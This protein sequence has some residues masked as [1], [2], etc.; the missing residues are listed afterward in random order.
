MKG[1][2]ILLE[3]LWE[4]SEEKI[5]GIIVSIIFTIIFK[6]ISP[7]INLKEE[8]K[9]KCKKSRCDCDKFM[10][11]QLKIIGTVSVIGVISAFIG[12]MVCTYF[13]FE[14]VKAITMIRWSISIICACTLIFWYFVTRKQ[15]KKSFDNIYFKGVNIVRKILYFLPMVYCFW[16]WNIALHIDAGIFNYIVNIIFILYNIIALIIFSHKEIYKYKYAK[17]QFKNRCISDV[18]I[19]DMSQNDEWIIIRKEDKEERFRYSALEDIE[20]YNTSEVEQK[21]LEGINIIKK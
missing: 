1:E 3:L 5:I 15:I 8:K 20:Y 7:F 21:I 13:N 19:E 17:L 12:S 14:I 6:I 4:A 9:W 16:I 10:W 2:I 18:P 11:H